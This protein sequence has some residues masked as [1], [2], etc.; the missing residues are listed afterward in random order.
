MFKFTVTIS[1]TLFSIFAN[2]GY[3]CFKPDVSPLALERGG[4]EDYRELSDLIL[5][6][7]DVEKPHTVSHNS[8][9]MGVRATNFILV[10]CTEAESLK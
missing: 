10:C 6:T 1:I 7:C 5:Q 8:S 9:I 3:V 4:V 2:A